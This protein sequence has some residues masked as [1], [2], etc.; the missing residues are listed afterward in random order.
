MD[1][2]SLKKTLDN[3]ET[4][5]ESKEYAIIRI[6]ACDKEAI[7]MIMKVLDEERKIKIELISDM[8]VTLSTAHTFIEE[9]NPA[10]VPKKE[11]QTN[12]GPQVTKTYILDKIA[13]FYIKY[14]GKITYSW[15]RFK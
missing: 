2:E 7:P 8:N 3:P 6:L 14:K 1:L 10:M 13:E 4:S 12:L 5:V 11:N 9:L 15:N